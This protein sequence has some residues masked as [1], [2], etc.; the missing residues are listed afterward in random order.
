VQ[1]IAETNGKSR[2]KRGKM[3]G[4]RGIGMRGEAIISY[5]RSQISNWQ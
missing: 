4:Q 5:F 3:E 2:G 1:R